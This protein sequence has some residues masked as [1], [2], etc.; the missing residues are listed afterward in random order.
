MSD[1]TATNGVAK[2]LRLKPVTKAGLA[3]WLAATLL[4]V[5]SLP[6][7]MALRN[8]LLVALLI[9]VL[10]SL[11]SLPEILK[12]SDVGAVLLVFVLLL[13]W[14]LCV[15]VFIAPET[16]ASLRAF[17]GEWGRALLTLI[18]GS[19]VAL[20]IRKKMPGQLSSLVTTL[21]FLAAL[22]HMIG[23]DV[24]AL[25]KWVETGKLPHRFPGITDHRANVTHVFAMLLSAVGADICSRYVFGRPLIRTHVYAISMAV[26]FGFFALLTSSTTNGWIVSILLT[27]F[28]IVLLSSIKPRYIPR[29]RPRPNPG[30]IAAVAVALSALGAVAVVNDPRYD[31]FVESVAIGWD[32]ENHRNWLHAFETGDWPVR[33]NGDAVDPS[34]YSRVAWTKEG[35][36][37]LVEHPVGTEISKH[38]FTRLIAE[39]YGVAHMSHSHIGLID[40]GLNAGIPGIILWLA[41]LAGLAWI[42]WSTAMRSGDAVGLCLLFLVTAFTMRMLIDSTLRDHILEQF[43]FCA[44]M[45]LVACA[46]SREEA[47]VTRDE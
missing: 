20:A 39:K 6:H 4:L 34:T 42:G 43:T 19:G 41:F 21:I 12:Q 28:I 16:V 40:F 36:K 46:S 3:F 9:L 35:I 25:T 17:A 29:A 8:L 23:H 26:V 38:T 31:G 32:T 45:L 10:R 7:V 15:S 22:V 24:A 11:F 13:A 5:F 37:L 1:G 30:A 14:M 2:W 47:S 33:A 27:L 18:A 44:G